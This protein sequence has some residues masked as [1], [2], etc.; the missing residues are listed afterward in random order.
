M[1][2]DSMAALI[3]ELRRYTNAG[4]SDSTVA[5][6]SYWTDDQLEEILD[7]HRYP[8]RHIPLESL[9]IIEDGA[10]V[11]TE[12]RVPPQF[13][14]SGW[15]ERFGAESA[16]RVHTST[17]GVAPAHTVNYERLTITFDED[18]A[19][20]DYSLDYDIYDLNGAA[21][22]V[23]ETKAGFAYAEVDFSTDNHRFAASQKHKACISMAETFRARSGSKYVEVFR[24][25]EMPTTSSEW[26]GEPDNTPGPLFGG[27][28]K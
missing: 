24:S 3:S 22:D 2:R 19:G 7:R 4:T 10:E 18:T 26:G 13:Q 23:W 28:Y 9:P 6:V 11:Y 15:V 14:N 25:D 27:E 21:A 20:A 12:Y 17:G 1:A 8:A 5:G 16:W